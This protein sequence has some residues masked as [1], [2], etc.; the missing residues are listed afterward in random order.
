MMR[1][2]CARSLIFAVL[3]V[4]A[5][6]AWP[7][8]VSAQGLAAGTE[9]SIGAGWHPW[10]EVKADPEDAKNLVVC[11]TKWDVTTNSPFGFVYFSSDGGS[12]WQLVL[13]DKSSAWVTEHSCAFG[14]KH[15]CYF[16]SGVSKVVD[17]KPHHEL[18]RTKIFVSVDAGR[19]W[20]ESAVTGWTDY[21][22]SAVSSRSGRL[23]TLFNSFDISNESGNHVGLV[24]FRSPGAEVVGPFLDP[25]AKPGSYK[26]AFPSHAVSLGDGSVVALYYGTRTAGNGLGADIGIVRSDDS[27]TPTVKETAIGRIQGGP[28]SACDTLEDNALAYDQIRNRLFVVF[29]S[30]CSAHDHSLFTFSDDEGKTWSKPNPIT[31]GSVSRMHNPSFVVDTKGRLLILW[32]E[33]KESSGFRWLI[34]SIDN[35]GA[36]GPVIPLSQGEKCQPTS[37]ALRTVLSMRNEDPGGGT[38]A[39][40]TLGVR[41]EACSVWRASGLAQTETGVLAVWSETAAEGNRL[42]GR[43]IREEST[44]ARKEEP[45]DTHVPKES[46]VTAS[47]RL[48]FAYGSSQSLDRDK[49]VLK[50]CLSLWNSTQKALPFPMKLR[51]EDMNTEAGAIQI[52]NATN[53]VEGKGAEWDLSESITGN[54]LAPRTNTHPICFLFRV[55]GSGGKRVT[56]VPLDLVRLRLRVLSGGIASDASKRPSPD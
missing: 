28:D 11:G 49:G 16:V 26:A 36:L 18:G 45:S 13:S 15:M 47:T 23:F 50:V 9:T 31:A 56:N 34:S 39:V 1:S 35:T 12:T 32:R 6:R 54:Q 48:L 41:S 14:P 53:H 37:E 5:G 2:W 40:L 44:A 42:V 38:T 33:E 55:E 17:G 21:S 30:G 43:E 52:L 10:Y 25:A 20:Q 3:I 7:F 46:D 22:T 4:V 19:H 8:A 29:A 24:V 51:A 27:D